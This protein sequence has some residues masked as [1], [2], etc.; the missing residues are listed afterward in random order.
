M[1]KKPIPSFA[2]SKKTARR[3]MLKHHHLLPPRRLSGKNG[4]LEYFK[5]VRSIQF[6][7]IN[8]VGRNPDLVLQSR[9]GNYRPHML[10]ELLYADRALLDGWDKMASIYLQEDFPYFSRRRALMKQ[11]YAEHRE[12]VEAVAPALLHEIQVH[13]ARSSLDFKGYKKTDWS[14]GPTSASRAGLEGLYKMGQLGISHRVS[15]RRY[16][17]LNER[18][19]PSSI[20]NEDDPNLDEISYQNWHI[21]R[22]L[23]SLGLAHPQ[24]G[25]HWLGIN[26]VN[27]KTR[28]KILA[29]LAVNGDV[30]TLSI[31]E[32]PGHNFYIRSSVVYLCWLE[33]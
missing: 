27:S 15:N 24:A 11:Y 8:L 33:L 22:R 2:I 16:Y 4:T 31:T 1:L 25:E 18:L 6:D 17:D 7:P 26:E 14:W 10:D 30:Q 19:L 9:V 12:I 20:L 5:H 21:L 3:F 28:Q 29:R 32:L 23:G 13:G